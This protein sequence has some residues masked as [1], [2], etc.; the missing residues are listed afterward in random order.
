MFEQGSSNEIVVECGN[1]L[2][3]VDKT[4]DLKWRFIG[5]FEQERLS[6]L[7]LAEKDRSVVYR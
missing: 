2:T 6:N 7:E 1:S 4:E 3:G 5:S